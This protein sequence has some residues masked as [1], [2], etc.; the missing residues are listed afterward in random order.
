[1][2]WFHLPMLHCRQQSTLKQ[3]KP[4]ETPCMYVCM[5]APRISAPISCFAN[6]AAQRDTRVSLARAIQLRFFFNL[7]YCCF[8][9][10]IHDTPFPA[11]LPSAHTGHRSLLL[12]AHWSAYASLTSFVVLN[13]N[14]DSFKIVS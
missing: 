9:S 1:M 13:Q 11:L 5:Y 4:A 14:K 2:N 10:R 8:C 7:I 3:L 6:Y 12:C